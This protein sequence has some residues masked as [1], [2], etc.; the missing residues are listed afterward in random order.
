MNKA[1]QIIQDTFNGIRIIRGEGALPKVLVI[2]STYNGEQYIR[3][4][5]DSVFMQVGVDVYCLVRDDGSFDSTVSILEEYKNK[6]VAHM[7][8]MEQENIG[9]VNS[10]GKLVATALNFDFDW[11]A[12]CD[13]DDVWKENKLCRAVDKLKREEDQS[14][15]LVYCSNLEL[16]DDHLTPI[17]LMRRKIPRFNE[18]TAT[19]QNCSAGC[20]QVY[21]RKAAELYCMADDASKIEMHD[22]W[23]FLIGIYLGKLIYDEWASIYYRQHSSNVIGA[24]K[25]TVVKALKN[26]S[27]G[28]SGRREKM[29][30]MFAD[31]HE[32]RIKEGHIK[33]LS[34]VRDYRTKFGCKLKLLFDI[35][36]RSYSLRVTL[37][38]KLRVLI[39]ALY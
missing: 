2:L 34:N 16:V 25:K 19:V 18:Y 22:Y 5:L 38:F 24:P 36:Y 6:F 3:E 33:I 29:I 35:R 1:K 21:N 4:Q 8:Y 12:F 17:G 30:R 14:I 39:N 9:V 11:I 27:N 13:Q 10:F 31:I 7:D 28:N 32:K 23:M 20:T 15:P 37:N 26:I